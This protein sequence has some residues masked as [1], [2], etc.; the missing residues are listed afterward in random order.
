MPG[1]KS[2]V[3]YLQGLSSG[4]NL[5]P[6]TM[7]GKMFHGIVSVLEEFANSFDRL[8]KVHEELESYLETIDQDLSTLEDEIY[9]D[10]PEDTEYVEV[11]C[12]NCGEAV[13]FNAG[14]LEDGETIEVTCPRCDEVVF[15]NDNNL[16]SAD[17]PET[18]EGSVTAGDTGEED[19]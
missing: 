6:E 4:M 7:E 11:G 15:V 1:L 9:G 13:S 19:V 14:I 2:K 8:E 16:Q 17:E 5:D 12:P 18:C 3:A 10:E